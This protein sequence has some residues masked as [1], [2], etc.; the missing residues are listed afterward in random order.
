M[1]LRTKP[2]KYT[3]IVRRSD[4]ITEGKWFS[5]DE[6]NSIRKLNLFHEDTVFIQ[7]KDRPVRFWRLK[8]LRVSKGR[9]ARM[10]KK[11]AEKRDKIK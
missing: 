5:K 7:A 3:Y 11:L 6:L 4:P 8:K 2:E 1:A 10:A 9:T